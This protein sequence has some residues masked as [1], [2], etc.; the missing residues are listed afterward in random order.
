MASSIMMLSAR[1]KSECDVARR[2]LFKSVFMN[3]G[4]LMHV[5]IDKIQHEARVIIDN[6]E[7]IQ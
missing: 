6:L 1:V 3:F 5:K 7:L 2:K 4:R